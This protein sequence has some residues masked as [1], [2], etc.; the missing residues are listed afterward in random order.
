MCAINGP[1]TQ[2]DGRWNVPHNY[3]IGSNV[4]LLLLFFLVFGSCVESFAAERET[5]DDAVSKSKAPTRTELEN[6]VYIGFD[7]NRGIKGPV[8]LKDGKW[9]GPAYVE[10]SVVRPM[11]NLLGDFIITGDL[12]GDGLDEA[13]TLLSLSTGGTGQLLYVTVVSRRGCELQNI[14]TR[15]IGD[16]VQILGGRIK[17]QSIIFDVV[18]V[19]PSDPSCCP[20]E[21]ATVGW[22]LEPGGILN[23][24]VT[25]GKTSRLSLQSI[26]A[27]EWVLWQW[28]WNE[29]A[30]AKPEIT[31]R[32]V[33]GQF[34]GSGGCNRYFAK[35][36]EGDIAGDISVGQIGSTRMSC[37]EQTMLLENRFFTQLGSVKKFGFMLGKLALTY[38]RGGSQDM[39]LFEERNKSP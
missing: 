20:G 28:G 12:D 35:A 26:A 27:T 13:V 37:N 1:Q 24:V 32:Y 3:R 21:V 16:R 36:S 23:P 6:A 39:M 14:A 29:P 38:Q 8:R 2:A 9:E 33:D 31:I 34:I 18:R 15:L 4:L 7:G 19:G 30:S 22:M 10:G 11:L 5:G 17:E 25:E